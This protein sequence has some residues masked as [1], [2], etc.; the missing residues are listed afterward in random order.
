M[1][2]KFSKDYSLLIHSVKLHNLGIYTCQAYNGIGKAASWAVTVR[3]KGPYHFTDP[4][5][6]KYQ[7]YIVK[8]PEEPITTTSTTTTTPQPTRFQYPLY[9]PTPEPYVPPTYIEPSNEIVPE[10][11]PLPDAQGVVVP[12][13]EGLPVRANITTNDQRYPVGSDIQIPC[14]VL[15]YPDPQVQWYKDGVPVYPSD[16][17]QI[18]DSNTLTILQA[19][20]ADSGYYQCEATNAYSKASSTLEILIEGMYIHPSCTDNQFFANCALIVKAKYCTHKYY[21]KFCCRSCTEAGLLPV[22]GP[23]LAHN[24]QNALDFNLV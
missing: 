15:G 20:K 19:T 18:S 17:I 9:R 13:I 21:A 12:A 1:N 11:Q 6:F 3:A 2:S 10:L 22:D 8:P 5:E 23:H 14:A 7:Q 16:K 24:K 4:N